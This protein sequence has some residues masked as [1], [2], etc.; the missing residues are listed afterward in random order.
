MNEGR[1]RRWPVRRREDRASQGEKNPSTSSERGAGE[2]LDA[3]RPARYMR[4]IKT[5]SRPTSAP[6]RL[7]TGLWRRSRARSAVR[8][9]PKAV[10]CPPKGRSRRPAMPEEVPSFS[11]PRGCAG[12][13][14]YRRT[15]ELLSAALDNALGQI[16]AAAAGLVA[17]LPIE[18]ESCMVLS[19]LPWGA[20]PDH[21]GRC[22]RTTGNQAVPGA[23]S[24]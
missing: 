14:R 8:N 24:R 16:P 4:Q 21:A 20:T 17:I 12:K 15:Q 7:L 5:L 19:P 13:W 22:H 1:L 11:Q 10:F 18:G 6:R 9:A 3:L 2:A 23:E